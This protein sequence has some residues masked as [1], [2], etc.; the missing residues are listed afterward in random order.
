MEDAYVIGIRLALDN[1]VSEGVAA[2]RGELAALDR[3]VTASA[4]QF[5]ALRRAAAS[6][7]LP[8][9]PTAGAEAPALPKVPERAPV[10]ADDA[11]VAGGGRGEVV[12]APHGL[13]RFCDAAGLVGQAPAA[14]SGAG[15]SVAADAMRSSL[16]DV[17]RP[18]GFVP[19]AGPPT[20]APP[21]AQP[22]AIVPLASADIGALRGASDGLPKAWDLATIGRFGLAARPVRETSDATRPRDD[23]RPGGAEAGEQV[24]PPAQPSLAGPATASFAAFAAPHLPPAVASKEPANDRTGAPSSPPRPATGA[25]PGMGPAL[26]SAVPPAAAET[27]R[28]M[29]GD[30][31]LDGTRVGRWMSERMERDA[32]RPP[33]GPTFFDPRQSPA[34]AGAT[35]GM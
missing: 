18:L 15:R 33:V 23:R 4:A 34:W 19:M 8:A 12:V 14:A 25:A 24:A 7:L 10:G 17:A 32:G 26:P 5:A 16:S 6:V 9:A 27:S 29:S 13:P 35:I 20:M 28:S 1:G 31:F 21:V 3:A 22:R 30:V 2:V 11:A